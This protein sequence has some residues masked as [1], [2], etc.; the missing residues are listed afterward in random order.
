MRLSSEAMAGIVGG[1][2]GEDGP[3]DVAALARQGDD[4]LDVV[5]TLSLIHI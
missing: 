3:K 1:V 2:V 4:G 5:L